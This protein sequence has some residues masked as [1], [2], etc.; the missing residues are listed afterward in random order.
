MGLIPELA[1]EVNRN[2]SLT[3]EEGAASTPLYGQQR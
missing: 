3:F 1:A 2:V